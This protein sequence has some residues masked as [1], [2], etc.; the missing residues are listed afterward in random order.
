MPTYLVVNATITDQAKLDEYLAAVPATLEGHE[1]EILVASNEAEAIE[2]E[3]AGSRVV[4]LRFKDRPALD[5]W[6][7]SPAYQ[8]VIGLRLAGTAGFGVVAEGFA[9]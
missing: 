8:E 1:V 3:P 4:V 2:G 9:P 7:H 6:Y 5:A